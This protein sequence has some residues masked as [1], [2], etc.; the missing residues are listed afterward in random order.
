MTQ[1]D[2]SVPSVDAHSATW[3]STTE[4]ENTE[5]REVIFFF[6]QQL[7]LATILLAHIGCSD[8]YLPYIPQGSPE[9]CS[10]SAGS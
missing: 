2:R 4:R 1:E 5:D 7:L 9:V 8:C 6:I 10:A 3:G